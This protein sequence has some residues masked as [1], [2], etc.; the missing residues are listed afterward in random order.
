[1]GTRKSEPRGSDNELLAR[2]ALLMSDATRFVPSASE[3][4]IYPVRMKAT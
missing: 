2:G 3:A 1:M 4:T